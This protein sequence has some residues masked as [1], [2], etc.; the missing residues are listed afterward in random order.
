MII[1]LGKTLSFWTGIL[2]GLFFI[3]SF[4]GCRCLNRIISKP[5]SWI[6]KHHNKIMKLTFA[7][8]LIH[9]TLGILYNL[10]VYI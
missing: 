4:L 8:F 1:I 6:I 7:L 10:G 5:S 3:L 9:A 2:V